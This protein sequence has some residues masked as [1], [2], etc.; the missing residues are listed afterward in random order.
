MTK[1]LV[2]ILAQVRTSELTWESFKCNVL[3]ALGADLALCIGDSYQRSNGRIVGDLQSEDNPFFH[4]AKHIFRYNDPDDWAVAFDEM[5]DGRW[6]SFAHIPGIWLGPAKTPIPHESSGGINTFFRWFL[7]QNLK[8]IEEYDQ[9][10]VTRSDYYWIKPHPVLDLDHVWVPNGEF[11]GGVCDR[12]MVVPKKFL[13]AFLGIPGT[14]DPVKHLDA[15]H[16]FV[17]S[18]PWAKSWMLN[19]ESYL[20]FMYTQA[21][22][23]PHIA[24][25]PHKM[26]TVTQPDLPGQNGVNLVNPKYPGM[27]I[28]YPD[29]LDDAEKNDETLVTWPW[30]II[31][32]HL[33]KHGMFRGLLVKS[34]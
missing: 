11:H 16:A 6:R 19:N 1:T 24:F 34:S 21:G 31:H 13:D 8:K 2:C 5:S 3:D 29:E 9:V 14:I 10:I 32:T 23:L 28:R 4:N 25:F 18:R 22:L 26:F 17:D 12:H 30:S 20:F 7:L 33:S 27:L 15:L